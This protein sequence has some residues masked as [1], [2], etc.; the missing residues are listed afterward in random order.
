MSRPSQSRVHLTAQQYLERV[1]K[2]L[3]SSDIDGAIEIAEQALA[4]KFQHPLF[5]NLAAFEAERQGRLDAALDLLQTAHRLDPRDVAILTSIGGV[6]TQLGRNRE[7]LGFLDMALTLNP[8][9]APAHHVSGLAYSAINDRPTA[10]AAHQRA[11]TLDPK[12][13]DPLGALADMALAEDDEDGARRLASSALQLQPDL[14]PAALVIAALDLKTGDTKAALERVDRVLAKPLSFLHGAAAEYMRGD[15]LDGLGSPVEAF[16][17]YRRANALLRKAY[18]PLFETGLESGIDLCGRLTAAFDHAS[19]EDWGAAPGADP[20]GDVRGHVFLV[21]FVRSGTTLLEQVLASHPQVVALEEQPT[22]RA[23]SAPYFNDAEGLE[24]LRTLGEKEAEALRADYWSRVRSFG[25]DPS[26]MIFVDKAPLSTRLLPMVSKLFPKA[27]VILALRDPR[28]V[29]V[30]AFKHRFAINALT[31]PFTD[32]VE[33]AKFYAAMMSLADVYGR[34][35]PLS[36]YQHR[37]E[38]LV[39]DFDAEVKRICDFI[40]VGWVEEMRDFAETA[41]RRDVRTPS[42]AQVRRGLYG[43]GM[44]RWRAYGP[45]TEPMLPILQPAVERYGYSDGE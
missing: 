10:R 17:S 8:S 45:G 12:Y 9:H 39:R 43:E 25:V 38:T 2:A 41:K 31:W 22:L 32:L 27:K 42:A 1:Q 34:V 11:A 16:G 5:L 33:T 15:L 40:G 26:E 30:S 7:A 20:T 18:G 3:A 29:V 35:L 24:R 4:S 14:A 6:L 28:D 37:H 23:I 44:G 13:P 36:V 21:G 19:P